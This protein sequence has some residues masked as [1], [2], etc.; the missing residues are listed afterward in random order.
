MCTISARALFLFPVLVAALLWLLLRGRSVI[1]LVAV[2]FAIIVTSLIVWIA[3]LS[4]GIVGAVAL[5][6]WLAAVALIVLDLEVS[7]GSRRGGGAAAAE[8]AWPRLRR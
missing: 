3:R 6:A 8:L 1:S 7:D 5:I 4:I 2:L